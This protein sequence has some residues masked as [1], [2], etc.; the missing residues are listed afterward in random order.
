MEILFIDESGDCGL[1]DGSTSFFVLAG[2]SIKSSYWKKYFWKVLDFRKHISQKYGLI[3]GELKGS[4]LFTHRGTFFNT[5]LIPKDIEIVYESAIDLI[6]DPF[7]E[8]LIS[9]K[10]KKRIFG[11]TKG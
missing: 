2:I 11:K 1:S 7:V 4:E 6:L 3:L 10:S 5:S 8:I 9:V